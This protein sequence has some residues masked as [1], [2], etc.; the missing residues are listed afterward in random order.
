MKTRTYTYTTDMEMMVTGGP[1]MMLKLD[2]TY[3][4]TPGFPGSRTEPSEPAQANIWTIRL[5][6]H[7]GKRVDV[8]AWMSDLIEDHGGIHAEIM[9]DWRSQVAFERDDAAD[10]K[11]QMRREA[12]E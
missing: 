3:S 6:D 5:T 8:P 1:T 11:L 7:A 9:S 10:H 4:V 2:I 12:A